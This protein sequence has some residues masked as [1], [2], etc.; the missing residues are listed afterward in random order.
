[1]GYGHF[2]IALLVAQIEKS[3]NW[4][5]KCRQCGTGF[6]PTMVK[7]L[8]RNAKICPIHFHFNLIYEKPIQKPTSIIRIFRK[9]FICHSRD[10][11]MIEHPLPAWAGRWG[12]C[13]RH[14]LGQLSWNHPRWMSQSCS[15]SRMPT[16]PISPCWIPDAY[17][18]PNSPGQSAH[19][20]LCCC[21]SRIWA[22][23]HSGVC[24]PSQKIGIPKQGCL[25][26][27]LS[28]IWLV[29]F[30]LLGWLFLRHR[31]CH[32]LYLL[33]SINLCCEVVESL[34][35]IV[36]SANGGVVFVLVFDAAILFHRYGLC[37]FVE[38]HRL[39]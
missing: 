6:R 9:N 19:T 18:L 2:R 31:R 30:S 12:L 5:P 33:R 27:S 11:E 39:D 22:M 25:E 4:L 34:L 37:G 16:V 23:Q 21:W 20:P 13:S 26:K 28:S 10:S 7:T 29:C 35:D 15:W 38:L 3:V 1:M 36:V 8:M 17:I 32:H 14:S 24:P